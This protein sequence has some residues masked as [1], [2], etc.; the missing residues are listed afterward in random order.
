MI[1][2]SNMYGGGAITIASLS[3]HANISS[4]Y[5][6]EADPLVEYGLAPLPT[7]SA[8]SSR[9][10]VLGLCGGSTV[11][12]PASVVGLPVLKVNVIVGLIQ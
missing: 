9:G 2:L 10:A 12:C 6:S 3:S 1:S 8:V 5:S 4:Y 7:H 11:C